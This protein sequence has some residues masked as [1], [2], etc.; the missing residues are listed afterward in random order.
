MVAERWKNKHGP[1]G[2]SDTAPDC[3]ERLE[4]LERYIYSQSE[5]IGVLE[6]TVAQ[7]GEELD[8]LKA[9][10]HTKIGLPAPVLRGNALNHCPCP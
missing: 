9:K 4:R 10:E 6:K 5:R 1:Y 7:Q 2:L 3:L 8:E